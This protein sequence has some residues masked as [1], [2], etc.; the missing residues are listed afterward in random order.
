MKTDAFFPFRE[1][2]KQSLLRTLRNLIPVR[3]LGGLAALMVVLV[4]LP[5]M[6]A[7]DDY[8]YVTNDGA[9]TITGYTG[10]GGAVTIP[11]VIDGLPVTDIDRFA[12]RDLGTLTGVTFPTSVVRIGELAFFGCTNLVDVGIPEGLTTIEANAFGTCTSLIAVSLPGSVTNLGNW[13]FEACVSLETITVEP[14]NLYYSSVEGVLF[15]KALTT[16]IQFPGAKAGSYIVPITVTNIESYAFESSTSLTD[17]AMGDAV[18]EIGDG[19][20]YNCVSLTNITLG[21]QVQAVGYQVFLGCASLPRVSLPASVT[22]IGE[23]AFYDCLSLAN[24]TI[25]DGVTF[26]D[27]YAFWQCESLPRVTIPASVARVGDQTF[28]SCLNL[29]SAFFLGNCPD[30]G[31]D[32]FDGDSA[33]TAYYLPGATGWGPTFGGAPTMLWNPQVQTGDG[34]FGIGTNGFGFTITGTSNLVIVVEASPALA[35]PAW[36]ALSTNTLTGGSSYFSDSQWTN[37]PARFYRLGPR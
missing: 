26:I 17:I 24:V 9:I 10:S 7:A 35:D 37:Y 2:C 4:M 30:T 3:G 32:V 22:G 25:P 8:T 28:A 18:S 23:E 13:V 1:V 12:F 11:G 20:F 16:L 34:S 15:N 33:V 31:L 27:D 6:V 36:S 19:A 14:L 21:N 29:V 5:V